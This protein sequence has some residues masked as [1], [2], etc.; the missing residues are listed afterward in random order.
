VRAA[1]ESTVVADVTVTV[2]DPAF[3]LRL[4]RLTGAFLAGY[5]N[6]NT[7]SSYLQQL[8]RW[9]AWCTAYQIDPLA[10]ERT[11]VEL[12]LGAD[13]ASG[14]DTAY[15]QA[16]AAPNPTCV[17]ESEGQAILG[18]SAWP[19]ELPHPSSFAHLS[20]WRPQNVTPSHDHA[21]TQIRIPALRSTPHGARRSVS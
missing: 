15:G 10:V 14:G 13:R 4:H 9:F 8:H 3:E 18:V 12:Y 17:M 20:G 21:A 19:V 16:A 11:H 6:A 5:R 2:L 7:R 1:A